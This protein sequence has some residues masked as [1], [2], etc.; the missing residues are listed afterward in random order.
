MTNG[1]FIEPLMSE[2]QALQA[3]TDTERQTVA[4]FA[5][6]RRREY[7]T[8]RAMLRREIGPAEI[9]YN[10]VGAP[11]VAG[12][13]DI[14]IGVSHGA[15]RVALCISDTPCAVDIECLDRN[16]NRISSRYL[17]PNE[18]AL[19][20]DPRFAAVVWCAKETLYKL[21]GEQGLNLLSDLCITA[22]GSG[23][24]EGSIKKRES[25]R[26]SFRYFDDVVVVWYLRSE[27]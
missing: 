14:C 13:D 19:S 3:A 4:L 18:R 2:E 9:I 1:L 20:S 5:A 26:L 25:R 12:C 24:I 11:I 10:T 22:V 27:V 21:S 6:E 17:T 16:F 7:L 8:W 23:W 15:G